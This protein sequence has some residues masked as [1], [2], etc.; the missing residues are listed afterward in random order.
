MDG[1]DGGGGR[2]RVAGLQRRRGS[3]GDGNTDATSS[4]PSGSN[5][6]GSGGSA[7]S[8]GT[9][10]ET[11]GH[12][13]A[14]SAGSG[15]GGTG[16]GGSIDPGE[17]LGTTYFV[18]PGGDDGND[19]LA[20]ASAF[21]T[22]QKGIDVAAPGDCVQLAAG[23]YPEDVVSKTHGTEA[24]PIT[25]VGPA[26]AV[27]RGAGEGRVLQ[28]H[29][30]HLTFFGFT[31][32]GWDGSG[33]SA[34]T[35]QDKL[36]YAIGTEA[37]HG[38]TGLRLLHMTI[39]NAGGECVRLRYL[40]TDCEIGWT[41]ISRCGVHD[42]EYAGGGKNG[43]GVYIG[44]AP[45]QLADGKNPTDEPDVSTGNWVHDC[46]FDTQ[47]NECVDIKEAATANIVEHNDCTGQKDPESAGFDSRGSGNT[48]RFNQSHGNLGA[49]VRLGGDGEGDGVGNDVHENELHD[50][51]AGGIKFQRAPQGKVCGNVC[52]ANAGGDAV[53][54]FGEQF[55][56]CAACP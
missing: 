34:D 24:M 26:E 15:P 51:A 49:G 53:G 6:N 31:I 33:D 16:S 39:E 11:G 37:G 8:G 54:D 4:N 29:H 23:D 7:P 13:P 46:T 1:C 9:T 27:L 50:N 25:I 22:I 12:A 55:D 10:G 47:G 30:D 40:A 44:T 35:Y 52:S 21:G 38:V 42:F 45:E 48:F 36:V 19:G 32:D 20:A 28:V 43:E 41:T 56:P 5:G 2:G 3:S 14:G 17:C 18:A